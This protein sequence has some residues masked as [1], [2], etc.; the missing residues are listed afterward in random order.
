M[1]QSM[2]ASTPLSTKIPESRMLCS[3]GLSAGAVSAISHDTSANATNAA[4]RSRTGLS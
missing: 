4:A 2:R 3:D 1:S